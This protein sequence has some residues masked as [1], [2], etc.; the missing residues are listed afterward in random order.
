MAHAYDPE[1]TRRLAVFGGTFDPPHVGHLVVASEVRFRGGFDAVL[2]MVAN[3]PWQK[4]DTRPITPAPIRLEMVQAAVDGHDGLVASDLEI[5]RGGPTYSIDTVETLG[6][7][8]S[9]VSLVLGA[10]AVAGLDTWHRA[11]DLARL[12]DIVAVRRPGHPT[13]VI[14]DRWR[15]SAIDVPAIDVSST[16]VRSRCADGAPTDFLV[17]EPVRSIIDRR[18]LYGVRR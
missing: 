3:D 15:V 5:G 4:R 7:D 10:D 1:M 11:D 2:L 16:G 18:G 13:P 6:A 17:T 12:V 14:S 9:R 8:G